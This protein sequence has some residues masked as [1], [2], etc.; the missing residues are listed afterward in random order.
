MAKKKQPELTDYEKIQKE[1]Q[2]DFSFNFDSK[3]LSIY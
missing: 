3:S 1:F 2:E